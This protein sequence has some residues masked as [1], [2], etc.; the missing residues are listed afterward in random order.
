MFCVFLSQKERGTEMGQE[1][2][3]AVSWG[4]V[5]LEPSERSDHE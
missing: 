3:M 2:G 4:E 5:S 1:E